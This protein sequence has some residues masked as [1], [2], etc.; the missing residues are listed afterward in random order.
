MIQFKVSRAE[1][2]EEVLGSEEITADKIYCNV[3]MGLKN[4]TN[5]NSNSSLKD[6]FNKPWK[7]NLFKV[8]FVEEKEVTKKTIKRYYITNDDMQKY[9]LTELGIE[10][11]S[12]L[13]S[14]FNSWRSYSLEEYLMIKDN[15]LY[16]ILD[17]PEEMSFMA[18]QGKMQFPVRNLHKKDDSKIYVVTTRTGTDGNMALYN[19][20]P[21][22]DLGKDLGDFYIMPCFDDYL[23][24]ISKTKVIKLK[25]G[26]EQMAQEEIVDVMIDMCINHKKENIFSMDLY[27]YSVSTGKIDICK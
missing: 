19:N 27:E 7:H 26:N 12:D 6:A 16:S 11:N 18:V 4:S 5:V 3:K 14:I 20:S 23:M 10:S 9:G 8:F 24:C 2:I 17:F 13:N 1:K 21:F 15:S 25:Q 22:V